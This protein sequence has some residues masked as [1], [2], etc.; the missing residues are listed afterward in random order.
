MD[1]EERG[2][3]LL[4]VMTVGLVILF[5]WLLRAVLDFYLTPLP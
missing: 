3:F 5:L 2:R 4:S 1:E